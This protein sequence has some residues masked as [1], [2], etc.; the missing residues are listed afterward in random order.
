[1]NALVNKYFDGADEARKFFD[2]YVDALAEYD[3][4]EE[5][6]LKRRKL[7]DKMLTA[8][9]N[10][11]RDE[12]MKVHDALHDLDDEEK[13]LTRRAKAQT[14]KKYAGDLAEIDPSIGARLAVIPAEREALGNML[15]VC[16]MTDEEAE[17]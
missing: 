13:K 12:K 16:R 1:M 5:L 15:N 7:A 8:I 9:E 10:R 6:Y 11:Q 4:A 2:G 14:V 3:R 17:K